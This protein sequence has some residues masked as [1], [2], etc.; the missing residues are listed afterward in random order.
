MERPGSAV[1]PRGVGVRCPVVV[2]GAALSCV[3]ASGLEEARGLTKESGPGLCWAGL[4]S[5]LPP[6]SAALRE[7]VGCHKVWLVLPGVAQLPE[8]RC[9]LRHWGQN[10]LW[11]QK[12]QSLSQW[13][14]F[15]P[16]QAY[17]FGR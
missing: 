12:S 6:R 10:V 11:N 1:R 15:T 7:A 17:G 4:S 13:E 5:L 16:G 2:L 9:A 8:L 14:G 3:R